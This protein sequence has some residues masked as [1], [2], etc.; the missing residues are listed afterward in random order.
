MKTKILITGYILFTILV[1]VLAGGL[2]WASQ[3]GTPLDQAQ[4]RYSNA[5]QELCVAT[6]ELATQKLKLG[7]GTPEE[8]TKWEIK[9]EVN[10]F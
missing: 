3:V 8:R 4:K 7:M 2:A 5:A 6:K 9:S 10:C 1:S